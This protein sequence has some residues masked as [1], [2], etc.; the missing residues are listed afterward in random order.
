M[1]VYELEDGRTVTITRNDAQLFSQVSTAG[2]KAPL[3]AETHKAWSARTGH[4]ILERYGLTET[5]MNTSNPY[6]GERRPG[7]RRGP[8]TSTWCTPGT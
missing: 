2:L 7:T 5:G 1:G 6:D 3:L 8:E 4:S